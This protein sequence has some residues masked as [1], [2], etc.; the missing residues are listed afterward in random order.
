MR[1]ID[2]AGPD[3][4]A[5]ALMGL[6]RSWAEQVGMKPIPDLTVRRETTPEGDVLTIPATSY[7]D[8]LDNFDRVWK[9]RI[10]YRFIN[11]PR[12]KRLS[13]ERR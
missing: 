4:N 13:G 8:L 12:E 3:G 10:S 7:N 5:F 11:D 1:D 9:D 6:S 2:L